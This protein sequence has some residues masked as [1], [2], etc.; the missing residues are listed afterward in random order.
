MVLRFI[1]ASVTNPALMKLYIILN[2]IQYLLSIIVWHV[3]LNSNN[4][5]IL[6]RHIV[7]LKNTQWTKIGGISPGKATMR[8]TCHIQFNYF[9]SYSQFQIT[10]PRRV[11]KYVGKLGTTFRITE[12]RCQL[13]YLLPYVNR[14]EV[15]CFDSLLF[16]RS[17]K[18]AMNVQ[19]E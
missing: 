12:V 19:G 15:H 14:N 18:V 16:A 4:E 11:A 10:L 17:T 6:L 8:R 2:F 5:V 9:G 3:S 1:K 13:P 7:S